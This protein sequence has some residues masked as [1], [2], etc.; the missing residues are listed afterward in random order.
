MWRI[1]KRKMQEVTMGKYSLGIDFG[2][3][4][5]RAI[6]VNVENGKP[7]ASASSPYAHGVMEELDF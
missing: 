5:A 6:L 3:L 1:A 7:I 2:S 4:S